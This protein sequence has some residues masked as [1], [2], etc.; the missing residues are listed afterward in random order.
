MVKH[1]CKLQVEICIKFFIQIC[2]IKIFPAKL[3]Q[4]QKNKNCNCHFHFFIKKKNLILKRTEPVKLFP[5]LLS[6]K[7][8][9]TLYICIPALLLLPRL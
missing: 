7:L 4:K 6:D 1:T 5:S 8:I 9:V 3:Y 2:T